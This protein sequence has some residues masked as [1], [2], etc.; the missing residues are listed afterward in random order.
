M[1]GQGAASG[2]DLTV[3]R[4]PGS[5]RPDSIAAAKGYLAR[6]RPRE[7]WESLGW[8]IAVGGVWCSILLASGDRLAAWAS[9]ALLVPLAFPRRR[10]RQDL[11]GRPSVM[12]LAF[13]TLPAV[14]ALMMV[15]RAIFVGGF[16]LPIGVRVVVTVAVGVM[17]AVH[18]VWSRARGLPLRRAAALG[19][20]VIAMALVAGGW[21]DVGDDSYRW[22]L[23]TLYLLG[24]LAYDGPADGARV[25]RAFLVMLALVPFTFGLSELIGAGT[26]TVGLTLIGATAFL[27]WVAWPVSGSSALEPQAQ[28]PPLVDDVG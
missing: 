20:L 25:L 14:I 26:S 8:T 27:A 1:D 16:L 22:V 21:L 4:E 10:H 23:A 15:V 2:G 11:S 17:G 19:V 12:F 28:A 5:S 7:E 18:T 24:L 9:L 3:D 6:V 13:Q